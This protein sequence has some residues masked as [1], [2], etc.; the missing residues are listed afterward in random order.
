MSRLA[1]PKFAID[2]LHPRIEKINQN[3]IKL[4]DADTERVLLQYTIPTGSAIHDNL[5]MASLSHDR[6]RIVTVSGSQFTG[7]RLAEE[8]E[9]EVTGRR[10]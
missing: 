9:I 4:V 7:N 1:E 2:T 10:R 6:K 3:T 5:Q 8:P